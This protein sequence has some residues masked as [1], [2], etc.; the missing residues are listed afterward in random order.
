MWKTGSSRESR[1]VSTFT[2]CGWHRKISNYYQRQMSV[3]DD[4]VN[5]A[6]NAKKWRWKS[7]SLQAV[8]L[9]FFRLTR[10]KSA[11]LPAAG[12]TLQLFITQH[13]IW[14]LDKQGRVILTVAVVLHYL[15]CMYCR[16]S[17]EVQAF[18]T[19][20]GLAGSPPM[21]FS[22]SRKSCAANMSASHIFS[23]IKRAQRV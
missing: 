15:F 1:C 4:S 2:S 11:G 17:C 19:R 23:S 16:A 9:E 12:F 22:C 6:A 13:D 7:E 3:I 14:T 21:T 8:D 20:P 5:V 18:C 10:K